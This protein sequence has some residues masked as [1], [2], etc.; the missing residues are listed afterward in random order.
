M[1]STYDDLRTTIS[2]FD[3]FPKAYLRLLKIWNF[4]FMGPIFGSRERLYVVI[5]G[6]SGG[7]MKHLILRM[8]ENESTDMN[9]II[10]RL[11]QSY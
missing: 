11:D 1:M 7:G 9:K 3:Y 10:Y 6:E 5:K 4:Y 8:G 2:G